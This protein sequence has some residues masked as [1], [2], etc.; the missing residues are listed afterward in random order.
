[1]QERDRVESIVSELISEVSLKPV[2]LE[3][4][5]HILYSAE[6]KELKDQIKDQ[7][8]HLNRD[9]ASMNPPSTHPNDPLGRYM[10]LATNPKIHFRLP[11][12]KELKDGIVVAEARDN[13]KWLDF[14][15][16]KDPNKEGSAPYD[17]SEYINVWVV[18]LPEGMHSYSTS[19]YQSD[20]VS[21]IVI[22][23]DFFGV[24]EKGDH[25]YV[26]GKTLTHLMGNYL[27]LRDLWSDYED[28]ADDAVEDTPLHNSQV[29]GCPEYKHITTCY[30]DEEV[31]S[32]TMNYMN[33][34]DDACQFMFTEG[35]VRRMRSVLLTARPSLLK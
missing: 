1:M 24:Q 14:D 5:F 26:E 18:D 13:S 28:C 35:Q 6:E 16:M 29:E 32:M 7:L 21:G 20:D 2:T 25:G 8:R 30:T 3:V 27:G 12:S 17:P 23:K 9:F 15:D 34:T 31:P 4:V 22:S 33:N 10:P 11:Q 19:P